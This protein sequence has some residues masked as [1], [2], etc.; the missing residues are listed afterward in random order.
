MLRKLLA[1]TLVPIQIV[2]YAFTLLVGLSLFLLLLQ[3]FIDIKPIL[4]TQT[5]VFGKN[6]A[7]VSKEVS[8]FASVNRNATYFTEEEISEIKE[9]KFVKSISEFKS[10]TFKIDAFT[11]ASDNVPLFHSDLF[12]ESVPDDYIDI[13][14]E[15]WNWQEGQEEIPIIIPKNY[16]DLYNSSF[17]QSQNLPVLS[18]GVISMIRFGVRLRGNNKTG[19][20]KGRVVGFSSK[21][22]SILVPQ[23]FLDWANIEYGHGNVKRTNRLLVEFSNPADAALLRFFSDRSYEVSKSELETSR[24]SFFVRII[25]YTLFFATILMV[26]LAVSF[27]FLSV[28]LM[29]QKNIDVIRNL[30]DIGF[31]VK[32]IALYYQ[33]IVI[34]ISIAIVGLGITIVHAVRKFYMEYAG[35][36]FEVS[37]PKSVFI[38]IGVV[39]ALGLCILYFF[40]IRQKIKRLVA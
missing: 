35:N 16:L 6:A 1:Q 28:S 12:F 2:G 14:N 17:S 31:S 5:E 34:A 11:S 4:E 22:N 36:Y 40:A 20:H 15:D 38:T 37:F 39:F 24:Q 10:A 13:E 7:V 29:L 9:Q 30:Y 26:V 3:G 27:V 23:S 18:E 25:F 19:L 8:V 32:E 33:K 21:I